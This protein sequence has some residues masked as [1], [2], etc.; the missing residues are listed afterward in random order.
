MFSESSQVSKA[1][2][3]ILTQQLDTYP[4]Q[5]WVF[6]GV[7]LSIIGCFQWGSHIHSKFARRRHHE[8]D[9]E[10]A[11]I[12]NIQ[13]KF[14]L[15]RIPLA[16]INFYRVVAFR[17]TLEIGKSYT[18]NMAEVLVTMT[19]IAL[20]LTYAFINTTSVEGQ[21]LD[22]FYWSNRIAVLASSQ[23][24]IV[25]AL[26]TK[27]NLVS[28]VTGISYDRLNYIHR[29]MA[30]TC[31]MLL[32]IHGVGEVIYPSAQKT[33]NNDWVQAGT[34]ALIALAVVIVV[35]LRPVRSKVYELF[36]YV[37]FIGVLA[38]LVA[39]YF[40]ANGIYGSY[41]IWPSLV[42]W[43]LDRFVRVVRLAVFNH[44]YF[45][46]KSGSGTMDATTEML[47]EDIVRVRLRR[48][49]HF[50]WS[51]GQA[52]YL[53]MPSVST[54]PFE[55][56]PFTIASFDSSLLSTAETEDQ[57]G[58]GENHETQVLGSSNSL[59]KELVFLVNVHGGFTKKLKEVAATKGT[60]KVF[61]DGPYGPSVDL[62][63]Y[64]TSVFVAGGSGISYT[65]PVL[66]S[67]IEQVRKGK[68]SCKRVVFIWS[69][70]QAGYVRWIEE[71]LIKAVQLAPPSLTVSIRIF[72]TGS[73]SMTQSMEEV[74]GLPNITE[75]IV[76]FEPT[77]SMLLS[78]RGV[79]MESGR[80]DLDALLKEEVSM[81]SGRM[82]VSV[83]GS[84][85]IA[86]AVRHALRFPVSGPSSVLSGGPSVTL[87]VE[88]FGYA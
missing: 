24:P 60:V 68:S 26:G 4:Q 65:V 63:S 71:A 11:P 50:H 59:W 34:I 83:C 58:G 5:V 76:T 3:T 48:P 69:I 23:F 67:V 20:L 25:T 72:N 82:S 15:R 37:H 42:I 28:L 88:S 17:W 75:K 22:I 9:E 80:S 87:Y 21:K 84:Y 77:S 6:I 79:K 33:S 56:H 36:F 18:L 54:L 35:S 13:Y 1:D 38:F 12:H 16:I 74:S 86:R 55:A 47:S 44:S 46:F 31:F 53:I 43:A 39:A 19:Y 30:R 27:N 8:S 10:T 41:W 29:M 32:C 70:R 52:A 7:S 51:P 49:P 66:L 61:V 57:S 62:G 64:D 40:H 45:G 14:S 81:A 85:G 2:I 78:L 73:P